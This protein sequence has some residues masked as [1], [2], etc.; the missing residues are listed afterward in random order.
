MK[1]NQQLA[2]MFADI[3]GS[4]QLYETVG[5]SQAREAT[6]R[7]IALLSQVTLKYQGS[8]IKTIGDEVMCTFPSSDQAARAAVNMQESVSGLETSLSYKLHGCGSFVTTQLQ[9]AIGNGKLS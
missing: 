4:T 2:I 3:A 7:C 6:S 5:N 8:V 1:N 9:A